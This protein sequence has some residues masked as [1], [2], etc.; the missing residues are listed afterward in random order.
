M[1][2]MGYGIIDRKTKLPV[3]VWPRPFASA[4]KKIEWMKCQDSFK[5]REFD[6]VR[7]QITEPIVDHP[8]LPPMK[9]LV[10]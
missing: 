4:S 9:P 6:I 1:K 5:G 7:I 3:G 2:D 10:A 8:K